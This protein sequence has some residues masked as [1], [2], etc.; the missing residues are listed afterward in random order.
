MQEKNRTPMYG[1]YAGLVAENEDPEAA[2]RL[3]VRVPS[4]FGDQVL[5]RWALPCGLP[6]GNG[7]GFVRLPNVGDNV[8]V[9][10]ANGD[11]DAPI[12]E[13]GAFVLKGAPNDAVPKKSVWQS[14]SGHQVLLDDDGEVLSIKHSSGTQIVIDSEGKIAIG[15]DTYSLAQLLADLWD[16]LQQAQVQTANGPAPF[17]PNS[18]AQLQSLKAN[19]EA[20]FGG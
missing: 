15:N 4:L 7:Y 2:A 13:Y 14:A 10:F 17:A 5:E 3:K 8:W 18:L 11:L 19:W 12:W 16:W 1:R 20:V 6:S 9:T